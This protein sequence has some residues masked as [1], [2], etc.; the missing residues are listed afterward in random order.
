LTSWLTANHY[1]PIH[2]SQAYVDAY[3]PAYR[4]VATQLIGWG[5]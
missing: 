1:P 5:S 2:H 3:K 4:L